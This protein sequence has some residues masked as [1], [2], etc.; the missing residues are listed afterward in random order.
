MF[1]WLMLYSH[2]PVHRTQNFLPCSQKKEKRGQFGLLWS[3][4]NFYL[5]VCIYKL[6]KIHKCGIFSLLCSKRWSRKQSI[7]NT[8][9]EIKYRININWI[10]RLISILLNQVRFEQKCKLLMRASHLSNIKEN[11]LLGKKSLSVLF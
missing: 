9:N 2:T 1:P 8:H 7:M 11:N 6:T 10:W 3:F 4:C 5:N